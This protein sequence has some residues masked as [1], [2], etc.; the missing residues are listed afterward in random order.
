MKFISLYSIIEKMQYYNFGNFVRQK[1]EKLKISLNSFA[2]NCELDPATLSNF[3]T[4]KSD[5]LFMNIAKIPKGFDMS[6]GELITEYENS[7]KNK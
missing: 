3:E 5:I 6:L 7:Q 2:L 4:S 1:R